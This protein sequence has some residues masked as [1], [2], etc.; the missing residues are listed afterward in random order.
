MRKGWSVMA[1]A[2]STGSS[3]N[4]TIR[5]SRRLLL[6]GAGAAAATAGVGVLF[7]HGPGFA[8][9]LPQ[10]PATPNV[11]G[12]PIPPE[13]SQ[14]ASDW[15]VPQGDLANHRASTSAA[16][17]SGNV[18]NLK[19]AWN[20]P[21]TATGA[22]GG[23]TAT[24]VIAGSSIYVQDMKSNVFALDR[25]SGKV[26]WEA[27]YD[28][29]T[30]GPNG[31]TL[32]YGMVYGTTGDSREVFALDAASGKEVWR[33]LLSGNTGE[34]IDMAPAV[35]GNVVYVSTVPGNSKVFYRGGTKGVIYALDAKSGIVL[36]SFD[37][38]TD[39][40]WGDP[41]V[42]NGGGCWYPPAVDEQGNLYFDVANPGPWPGYVANGTPFPNGT[43]RPGPN[44]YTN[45]LIALT[46]SGN[47]RWFYNAN[48]HDI[49]DHDLQQ[50]P[51]LAD[52]TVN[53]K[54]TQVVI[55]S[56]KLGKVLAIERDTGQMIWTTKVGEHNQWDDAQSVPAG[57]TVSVLPGASGGVESPIAYADGTVFVP[58]M[59]LATQFTGTE[60]NLAGGLDYSKGS[61]NLTALNVADGSV[62]WDVKLPTIDVGGATVAN[63]VV[64][65]SGLD[66]LFRAFNTKDGSALWSYQAGAGFNAP[67]AIAGD[68]VIVGA[69]GP[70]VKPAAATPAT[71]A[72]A[73]GVQP[74]A[75]TKPSPALLAFKL[76]S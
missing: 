69:A 31:V 22:F 24:P 62:K 42:N 51:V 46:P 9:G 54:T 63:D 48:P 6:T 50:S 61:G 73:A 71:P 56:G 8:Q 12:S 23:F 33:T 39:N 14:Y 34:G 74:T 75:T 26:T 43:S 10:G 3:R 27:H 18:S 68:L 60:I 70:L 36:W 1:D 17:N 15:P 11:I 76:G 64:F 32:G 66:G 58:V 55:A 53:G 45:S 4:G 59:N 25:D 35:F 47:L 30:E 19:L 13:V 29:P 28:T 57:Q 44:D 20:F 5:I 40:L 2:R 38:T 37:T 65:T 52:I 16:I 67:P 41:Q 72:G 21:I 49:F 7:T